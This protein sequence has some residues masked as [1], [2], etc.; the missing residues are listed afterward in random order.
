MAALYRRGKIYWGRA[1]RSKREHRISLQ[2]ANR[3]IAEKRLRKWLE[4]LEGIQWGDRPSKS[5]KEAAT[6]FT[7]EHLT[8]LK[9]KSVTR[10]MVSLVNLI[11]FFG[12]GLPLQKINRAKLSEF[13]TA[14]RQEGVTPGTIRRD[15]ACLS[16]LMT[17]AEDWEWLDDGGNPVPAYLRRRAKRGLKEAP[18]RTRYLTE[19]EEADLLSAASPESRRAIILAIETGLRR[20]E[21]F[22]LQW[23]QIDF[24]RGMIDTTTKTKNGRARKVPLSERARTVVGT[25]PRV[26]ECPYVLVNSE[27]GTRYVQMNKG[28]TACARRAKV[29]DVR[30]HDFRRTAGC[31]WL[32]RDGRSMEEVSLLL[33]HSSVTVTE[34]I[35]AFLDA[36]AV[37][38]R[39][40]TGT[41]TA[42][43]AKVIQLKQGLG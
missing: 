28:L 32:Q 39:T 33:G 10:Y 34:K 11:S 3:A 35:Y 19:T 16:S 4:E 30:W 17:S 14:R 6:K 22:G 2:T 31:R 36:E 7:A 37:A 18:P 43:S 38:S 26:L 8:T 23:K 20:E 25:L 5:L 24:A 40:I 27:T 1:Q 21:L 15:L 12:E 41:G 9:P 13:E 29:D 42:D